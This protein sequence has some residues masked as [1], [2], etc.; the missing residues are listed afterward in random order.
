MQYRNIF[1]LHNT[2]EPCDH[3]ISDCGII[4]YAAFEVM[5]FIYYENI[6]LWARQIQKE[7]KTFV[8]LPI[9]ILIKLYSIIKCV[10][11]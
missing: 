9:I 6:N 5:S 4:H 7:C 10:L 1:I 2:Q 8:E 3:I 11:E